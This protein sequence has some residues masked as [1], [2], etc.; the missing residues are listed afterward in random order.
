MQPDGGSEVRLT[1]L[2]V[3]AQ[4]SIDEHADSWAASRDA[5]GKSTT[6]LEVE[7]DN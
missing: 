5:V 3:V 2:Q 4:G 7:A 1:Y 6:F